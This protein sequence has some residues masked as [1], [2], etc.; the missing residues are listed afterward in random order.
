M[1]E[2][3]RGRFSCTK[4]RYATRLCGRSEKIRTRDFRVLPSTGGRVSIALASWNGSPLHLVC[5]WHSCSL[6]A[7]LS[8]YA[9]WTENEG[10]S[11]GR[12]RWPAADDGTEWAEHARVCVKTWTRARRYLAESYCPTVYRNRWIKPV[13]F[14]RNLILLICLR[15]RR[16][17]VSKDR[18]GSILS[19]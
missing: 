3:Q 12:G 11:G 18:I 15:C 8:C 5:A 7:L 4:L 13:V 9:E 19:L 2:S 17:C 14:K 1:N 10:R 16:R 6:N